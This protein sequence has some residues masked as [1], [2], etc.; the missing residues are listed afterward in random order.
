MNEHLKSMAI[1]VLLLTAAASG[2]AGAQPALSPAVRAAIAKPMD[3]LDKAMAAEAAAPPATSDRERL[4]R[5]GRIDQSWRQY[6]GELNLERLSPDEATAAYA[7]IAARTE[8]IDNANLTAVMAM[9]PAEGWFLISKYGQEAAE[10][11]F[12]IVQ[13]SDLA[14]QQIVLPFIAAAAAKGEAEGRSYAAMYDRVQIQQGKP[15]RYGTQFRCVDH[16]P[17]P[18][19]LEDAAR[20]EELRAPFKL[21]TTFAEQVKGLAEAGASC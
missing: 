4:E 13:H 12:H 17:T 3:A 8:P 15:Q 16:R 14:Q 11:A 21:W 5:M 19:P 7:A 18:Y 9:R 20:V 1:G 2:P 10:A 6:M